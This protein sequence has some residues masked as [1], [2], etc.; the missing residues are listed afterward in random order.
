MEEKEFIVKRSFRDN[1][2]RKLIFN[3]DFLKFEN[4]NRID[5]LF[6]IFPKHE[7][8]DYR[9]GIR[10]IRFELTYGREYQIFIRNKENK[11]IKISFKSYL[12]RNKNKLHQ[13]Y[14][15]IVDELWNYFI[16]DIVNDFL[17]KHQNGEEFTIG[18]VTFYGDRIRLNVSG[19]FNQNKVEIS[20]NKIR[21]RNY[22]SYFSI[23]SVDNPADVNRGYSYFEDWNTSV[24]Y[25]V[26][27]TILRDEGI[28]SYE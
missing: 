8:K 9:F 19:I 5:D 20:W 3:K 24:L 13:L 23:Y 12:G 15:E 14:S 10:W 7:I 22:Y 17:V 25:S 6:T 28:E 21:T 18:D 16:A 11:I 1:K 27:R 2:P 4:K 26:I